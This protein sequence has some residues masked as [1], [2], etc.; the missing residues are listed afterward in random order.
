MNLN[1]PRLRSQLILHEALRL[2]PYDDATGKT[3]KPGDPYRGQLTTGVGRNLDG[4]PL[5]PNEIKHVGHNAREKAITQE[6]AMYLLDNDIAAVC[7][8]LDISLPWWKY[9]DEIRARVLVDLCFNMGI[10]RLLKFKTTLACYRVGDFA[11]AADGLKNSLWYTQVK[12]RG[13]RLVD[14][15]RTG[16]DWVK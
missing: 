7:R 5:S 4:N 13:E 6:Q 15:V 3:V 9:L 16:K 11:G 10:A 8:A 14:M 12:S 1:M 2:L